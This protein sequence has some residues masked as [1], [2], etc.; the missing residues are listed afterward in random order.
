MSIIGE[1]FSEY[2]DT[3]IK[4]RQ[5]QMGK[6]SNRG[7]EMI[8]WANSKTAWVKLSSGVFLSG[9]FAE[10]RLNSIGLTPTTDYMGTNL[11]K[12]NV[13]FGGVATHTTG[14]LILDQRSSFSEVYD[15]RDTDF[16]LVPMSGIES[17]DVKDRNRGSIKE[18]NVQI[19]AYSR[20][21]LEI[22]DTLFLRLGYTVLLEWGNSHYIDNTGTYKKMGPT[23]TEDFQGMFEDESNQIHP[24]SH[25]VF[26][27]KV[28]EKRGEYNGNYDGFLAKVTNF[29]WNFESDG[30][31]KISLKLIS[32]GDVIESLKTN[33]SFTTNDPFSPTTSG[34]SDNVISEYLDRFKEI[35]Q[36][37]FAA[38]TSNSG[39]WNFIK[40]PDPD[41]GFVYPQP[42]G[43]MVNASEI[44]I[45][46]PISVE[47]IFTIPGDSTDAE[48][49]EIFSNS[50]KNVINKYPF[51][52]IYASPGATFDFKV[53]RFAILT[54]G[55]RTV[56]EQY[57]T[58]SLPFPEP[59]PRTPSGNYS[60]RLIVKIHPGTYPITGLSFDDC[61]FFKIDD[62]PEDEE[63]INKESDINY[64]I[65]FSSLLNALNKY[66]I[67]VGN[68]NEKQIEIKSTGN[69][70]YISPNQMSFDP[71]VCLVRRKI[72]YPGASTYPKYKIASKLTPF[73]D[74]INNVGIVDNIYMNHAKVKEIINSKLDER[75]DLA[76]YDFLSS[77][78]DEINKALGGIN[79]LEPVINELT[80]QILIID[81]SL[82]SAKIDDP[83]TA[84]QIYG[85]SGSQST[86]VRN[87]NLQTK[88][89]PEFASMV[90]IGST[91]AG[92][93]KGMEATAFS[94]WNRGLVDRFQI[95]YSASSETVNLE[96]PDPNEPLTQ[97]IKMF[98]G[99]GLQISDP[100]DLQDCGFDVQND[101]PS[102]S[103]KGQ[104]SFNNSRIDANL[105]VA[106][107]YFKYLRASSYATSGSSYSPTTNG[108]IPFSLNLTMDGLSGMKIYNKIEVD[109]RFLPFNYPE[110]IKYIVKR[111]SHKLSNGDWE[112]T[113]ET[114]SMPG[115]WSV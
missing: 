77:L 91:A 96:T 40:L 98:T 41:V 74:S 44:N 49:Q 60:W 13:L 93:T 46:S 68:G 102:D 56:F 84:F 1:P 37:N 73:Y 114:Q 85:Y 61:A 42:Q 106:T 35:N 11:A 80:N 86:F 89:S 4:V 90:T 99:D 18:A 14:S 29:T 31:Y 10:D 48:A 70:C 20:R 19:K 22:I 71:R 9:S 32:L 75:G 97:Y 65:K 15:Y 113:L 59:F 50:C 17:I 62:D 115:A 26:L 64:Y 63:V 38:S 92:Y 7:A 3:Q 12:K 45:S 43:W 107:E 95:E 94:K 103:S 100:Y 79:N 21:Q 30:S 81:S 16:G 33:I 105:T 76:L 36:I 112:T 52:I 108:F 111:V 72:N 54:S 69:T 57:K 5:E 88:I 24:S 67:P 2:V 51:N 28:E 66:C 78:C 82:P 87:V 101:I 104:I 47:D 83:Q 58:K 109:T 39:S 55:G 8:A 6:S 53:F 25:R 34:S 27:G 110:T 23:L